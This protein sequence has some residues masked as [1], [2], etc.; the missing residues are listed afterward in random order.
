MKE[1]KTVLKEYDITVLNIK[2][3][4]Y[5]GKKGVWWI[6]T[7]KDYKILKKQAYSDKTL[8]FIIAAMEHLVK[9]GIY[10]PKIIKTKKGDSYVLLNET[11]YLLSEAIN[12]KTLNYNSSENI[13]KIVTELANFH[14]ASVGFVPPKG[15]KVRTHLGRWIEKYEKEVEKLK[16]YYDIECKK[17]IH[18][19]FGEEILKEFPYFYKRMKKAIDG[20]NKSE[21][22]KWVEEVKKE[23]CL[24]HQDFTA[25]N[26]IFTDKNEI[27]VLDL[28]S[29]TIDIPLRD[30]RKILN[31]IMKRKKKWDLTLVRDILKW[32]HMK[33]P[34][35]EYQWQVLKPTL[36]YPHL[37]SGI[38]GKYYEKRE[39]TWT[40]EKYLRRL[41]EM[42]QIDKS[43]DKVIENFNKI[44]P[45]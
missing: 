11:P 24:C 10:I 9:N 25:G 34:L 22:H 2:T 29:I 42:I 12:G 33:N 4:S 45:L 26:L 17:E 27:Y 37:F 20:F 5:K 43:L 21:Y 38:M 7:Q 18:S 8:E 3:E 30:I 19:A 40:E 39:K 41:K 6:K 44:L 36:T 28:D 1:I 16:N 31:K 23:G 15:C 14:R 35:K 13:K 32:Y